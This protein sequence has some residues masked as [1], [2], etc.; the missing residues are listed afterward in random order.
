[1]E[2]FYTSDPARERLVMLV[3]RSV[4][5]LLHQ[6]E[7]QRLALGRPGARRRRR[8]RVGGHQALAFSQAL[9]RG[10]DPDA[11]RHLGQVV[12]LDRG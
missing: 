4:P 7:P 11:P 9:L 12:I 3:G 10:R 2:R 6:P 8:R 1:M 5:A